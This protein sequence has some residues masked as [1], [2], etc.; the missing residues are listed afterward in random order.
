MMNLV[1][2][3]LAF[4]FGCNQKLSFLYM[5]IRRR[6]LKFCTVFQKWVCPGVASEADLIIAGFTHQTSEKRESASLRINKGRKAHEEEIARVERR[7]QRLARG[8]WQER[9]GV[10][11]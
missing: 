3:P 1:T 2:A 8:D 9:A 5:H 11:S 6:R 4:P 7:A 10:Y